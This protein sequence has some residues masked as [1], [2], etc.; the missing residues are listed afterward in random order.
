M[1][2]LSIIIIMLFGACSLKA[3]STSDKTERATEFNL[4]WIADQHT[5]GVNKEDG[6]ASFMPYNSKAELKKDKRFSSPWLTPTH[7]MSLDLNGTWKFKWI[8]GTPEGPAP[9]EYQAADFDD[10]GW[11]DIRVPMSWEMTGKYNL[12]TYNNTGYP[13]HNEPP[14]ARTGFEEHG[15]IDH[16]ATGFYRRSFLLPDEWK[17]KRTFIHFDG[18]YSCCVVW[19]NGKFVGYSQGANNVAEFEL[20]DFVKKGENQLSVR[21]YRWCDGSYLEGQ[22]MWRLSGIHRDV[23]LYATPKTYIRDHYITTQ[24]QS[25]DGKSGKLNVS[26]E[27]DNRKNETSEKLIK[28]EL[29]DDKG[30]I[31]SS[32]GKNININE[33]KTSINL[34]TPLLYNLTPWN[35][36]NPYLYDVIISQLSNGKEE[37]VFATKYGFRKITEVNDKSGHYFT[38]NGKRIFFKGVN[39]HDSHPIYGRYVD[40]ETMLRD[41]T[42]MKQANVN[43][44][45]TSH[46]PRHEKMNAMFDAFGL[47]VMDEADLE[48]HGNNSLTRNASWQAAFED[49]NIRMVMRDR[50]HPSV[51]FWSLGNENGHGENMYHCYDVVR[52]LDPRPIHCHGEDATDMY[53]E[54]YTSVG[55]AQRLQAGHN[56]K[57]FF[58]CEYAHAMG[59]AVGNLV[60]YWKV[61]ERS[62]GIVGACIW[63]WVDQAIYNPAN[64]NNG[65]LVNED[66]FHFLTGG[67]DYDPWF[68]THANND[69]AFQGNFLNNGIITADRKWTAKLT[70]V[71]KVYQH[72]TFSDWYDNSVVI[73]NKYPFNNLGDLFYLQYEVLK[74][75]VKIEQGKRDLNIAPLH[76]SRIKIPFKSRIDNNNEYSIIIGLCLK[77][78]KPWAEKGY[79][80]AEEQFLLNKRAPLKEIDSHGELTISDLTVEGKIFSIA[81][82]ENGRIKSYIYNNT[83]LLVASPEYNDFR[84][85]D[86]DNEGKQALRDPN[87]GNGGYDYA[88][89]GI[90]KYEILS[91]LKQN[92]NH[93]E[94]TMSAT[95]SKT[96]YQVTY[97]IYP[98]GIMDMTVSFEPQRRGLRRLGMGWQFAAGFEEVEY[99]AKGPWSN[100]KDR[101]TGSYLGRYTTTVRDMI[102]ENTHPQTYG[103]H[104]ALRELLLKN[105]LTGINLKIETEGM[106]SFS[107]SHYNE[108]DWNHSTHFTKLHWSDLKKHDTLF[109]HF[110]YWH[111]GIG[112]NSC[113]SDC[114]LTQ[115]ETPYP[116]NY[117]GAKSLTYTLR[118]IPLANSK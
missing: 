61:I 4:N 41:I 6:H 88:A 11:D 115:Y 5:F 62:S 117:Q 111:R 1:N 32:V 104:Q 114:S 103:D 8:Q 57:P 80:L 40:N 85:I 118:F 59:Q 63:D 79:R 30:K 75:G 20:T 65:K 56:G 15:I 77:E 90:E 51:I 70:E 67:Y 13:F 39:A 96:N 50:N 45:R 14:Y 97:K 105:N 29:V 102:D 48:C 112:N 71:K 9:S 44:I 31:I 22:D 60:D 86:N 12:P 43:T 23:Y 58:I 25:A 46:Y 107:L 113:F 28:I 3:Q 73:E 78:S 93:A 49:R 92:G 64:I 55:S 99:Y 95:G 19:V 94:L 101:Q 34:T 82:D 106:V 37:M 42:L 89:T 24:D 7:A 81:F 110:D 21:V 87:D 10:S 98:N 35:A 53:S 76:R 74:N 36:E 91:D 26:L 33:S 100:F 84:R 27:L 38:I 66:G 83:E 69:K 72:V 16:N 17:E 109:A 108:L 52:K 2:K 116:G 18:V 68:L 54:M 47:Y